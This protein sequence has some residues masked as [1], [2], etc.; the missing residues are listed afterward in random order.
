MRGRSI[1]RAQERTARLLGPDGQPVQSKYEIPFVRIYPDGTRGLQTIDR[2][3]TIYTLACKF[4]SVGGRYGICVNEDG[5]VDMV[6][7][8]IHNGAEVL[9]A[10]EIASNDA[11]LLEATDKLVKASVA[12]LAEPVATETMQ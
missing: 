8:M 1:I 2:G 9:A 4:I 5:T 10:Q 7:V 12:S 6:A 11:G 3:E